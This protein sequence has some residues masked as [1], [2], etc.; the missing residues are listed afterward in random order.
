MAEPK[1]GVQLIVFAGKQNED[2]QGVM[3]SV[4][5]VGYDAA[6]IGSNFV[7]EP[8]VD[9]VRACMEATGLAVCGIHAGYANY[10]DA[11]WVGRA[12]EFCRAIDCGYLIC[13][14]VADRASLKGYI[15]SAELFNAVGARVRE[16][17]LTF[18]YHNHAWEFEEFDG[19][20]GIHALAA[21]TD[22]ALVQLNVDV[23]WVT[24]GGE[25]PAEF[26]D[27]YHD[28]VG[29]YHFKDGAPGPSF[30]E[31]GQGTVDLVSA[32]EAAMKYDPKW[33]VCEQDRSQLDPRE[34]ITISLA[35]LRKIGF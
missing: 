10:A 26:I 31:L 12:I 9:G 5:E 21:A 35:Y 17:G 3:A 28:R 20:K 8:G 22:P 33:I 30:I 19:Q 13:S 16:A 7:D 32:R 2:L 4:A 27:R 23:Y 29:Y 15:D 25:D 14:G 6:E 18:C 1:L 34:S 11:E 24:I